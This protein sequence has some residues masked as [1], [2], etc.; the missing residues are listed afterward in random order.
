MSWKEGEERNLH[1]YELIAKVLEKKKQI[2]A[3][4]KG[5]LWFAF[6]GAK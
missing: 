2:G 5:C 4:E 1:K 3:S 6:D